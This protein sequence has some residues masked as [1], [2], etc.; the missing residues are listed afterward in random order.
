M[1]SLQSCNFSCLRLLVRHIVSLHRRQRDKVAV[2]RGAKRRALLA[3][4]ILWTA[5]A[6]RRVGRTLGRPRHGGPQQ[7]A[8]PDN[9]LRIQGE[10]VIWSAAVNGK[11]QRRSDL[12]RATPQC[13]R[14]MP[15]VVK[16]DVSK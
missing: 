8:K 12:R 5:G 14:K 7:R 13:L 6:C 2:A 4:A 16:R 10:A 11:M 9:P 15:R 3:Q 1:K